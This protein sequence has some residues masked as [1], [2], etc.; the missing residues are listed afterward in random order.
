MDRLKFTTRHHFAF[1][2]SVPRKLLGFL[3]C[4]WASLGV[5][6]ISYAAIKQPNGEYRE[7]MDDLTVKVLGGYVTI[8]R[9]WQ[10]D[11]QNKG[12]FRW[13]FNPAWAD[14]TFTY[15][16]I[17]GSVK[18]ITRADSSFTKTGTGV[19]VFDQVFFIRQTPTGW[20]WYNPIGNWITYDPDGKITAYGDRNNVSVTF[21]RNADGTINQLLDNNSQAVLTY[22]YTNGQ[23]TKIAD[24]S[25]RS[26]SYQYTEGQLT[27]VTD[28]LTYNWIYGYTG[29]LLTSKMD[30]NNHQ[31][32]I[33]YSGNRVVKIKDPMQYETNYSYAY[34][35][36]KRVYTV[37]ETSPAGVRT[38][39]HYDT[40]GKVI[41]RQIGSRVV[42]QMIKDGTNVEIHIDERGL[43]TRVV[44]DTLRNPIEV[45]NPDGTKTTTT[46]G[47]Q[48]NNVS[49]YT[50]EAGIQ[51][52]YQYDANGNLTQTTE[53]VGLP[54][55]RITTFTYDGYGQP[56]TRTIKGMPVPIG[57]TPG[58]DDTQYQD[59]TT[60]LTYD[61]YGNVTTIADPMQHTATLTEDVMGNVLTWKDARTFTTKYG[62][63]ARGWPI[64]Q[65]DP[66]G[67]VVGADYDKV[68]N[69]TTI[70][71][72]LQNTT[73]FAYNPND[74]LTSV[75]D[76]PDALG[77]PSGV[78][79]LDY[80]H[81][82]RLTSSCDQSNVCTGYGYDGDGR[83][84]STTDG[85]GNVTTLQYGNSSNG[86][87]GLVAVT[88]YPT[89]VEQYKYDS[90]NRRTQLIQILP[91][92]AGQPDQQ[93]AS[94]SGY[95][96]RGNLISV[97]DPRG[98]SALTAFD[99]L[100]RPIQVTDALAGVTKQ[101]YNNRDSV[102]TVTDAN[103]NTHTFSYDLADRTIAESRPLGG[104]IRYAYDET[105]DLTSRINPKGERIVYTYD[106]AGRQTQEDQ[107]PAGSS[108]ASQTVVYNYDPRDLLSGYTQTGDTLSSASYG[109]DAKG[110]KKNETVTY[111]AG[112]SAFSKTIK[113][114]YY[115]N[116]LKQFFT[117]PDGTVVSYSY[118]SN[119]ELA[120][121]T[122]PNGQTIQFTNFVWN[123]PTQ[124][125]KPG[126]VRNI[127]LD[128]L[129]RPVEIKA[130]A[131][132]SG[133]ANAP[134][135]AIVMNY[136]YTYDPAGNITKRITEDGEYDYTYDGLYRLTSATPPLSVQRS[137]ANP[138]GLPVEQYTYDA[139]DNRT[140]SAHQPGPWTYNA[141]NQLL[142]Y[143]SGSQ[144]QTYRYDA[145]GNTVQQTTGDPGVS[146]VIRVFKY[147]TAE[148][149]MEVEDNDVSIGTYLYDPMGRR[150]WKQAGGQA[151]WFQYADEGTVAEYT[152]NGT[153]E[154][155]YGLQPDGDWETDPLW[156]A[157]LQQTAWTTSF[158]DNDHLG[159][160]Q[161]ATSN[162]GSVVWSGLAEAFGRTD[163]TITIVLNPMRFPGQTLDRETGLHYN[164]FREYEPRIGRYS[165]QDPAGLL[166]GLNGYIYVNGNPISAFDPYGLFY[167]PDIQGLANGV[168]GFG[169]GVFRVI[170]FGFG[171]LNR[172]RGI[173]GID[174]G[175]DR[176]SK[177]YRYAFEAG[178]IE[179][180]FALGGA[181]GLLGKGV[182]GFEF[183]H[184]VPARY[185]KW[186]N[187]PRAVVNSRL[188]GAY[189][190]WY[191]HAM[192][193]VYRWRFVPKRLKPFIPSLP[194]GAAQLL[195]LPP[196]LIGTAAG[197]TV[198]DDCG[199]QQ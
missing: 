89:F 146:N 58:P 150:I 151:T 113:Y 176:C 22:T 16:S 14:L 26:V 127:A 115:P 139:V 129:Q 87:S 156:L 53:A 124:I 133:T 98:N 191:F 39:T 76:A 125:Q 6:S 97:T 92:S 12:K 47:T 187:L 41:Y 182:R 40:R 148:R 81:D 155:G 198:S 181:L 165:R 153:M 11:D 51:T 161:R 179:G 19:F 131:I 120:S 168:T 193:D 86:L 143:G 159:A 74:W 20:R 30:P 184:T 188:N 45:D 116:G 69:R 128:P 7:T 174:G 9:T 189:V 197:S 10:A 190:P 21:T 145:N 169:D 138:S 85:A 180:G 90:R 72:P 5:T 32:V 80:D 107:Y 8:S 38:E 68:G 194:N 137:A 61:S 67:H 77:S 42:S 178:G 117:Y 71:D 100:N 195:R 94:T 79:A 59:A 173:A 160:S 99:A 141:D 167:L 177:V 83:L 109:Y 36:F 75:T 186:Y 28:P 121:A 111:G 149:P 15:D 144:Q 27:Q 2:A 114:D 196:W 56:L 185:I 54:E 31:T 164:Y 102:L 103:G 96:S 63:N 37:V 78:S 4:L 147:N 123:K 175:I 93:L 62:Y 166:T 152:Q 84:T 140:S 91:G 171:D 130:Q 65:T 50:D 136:Q 18:Q 118:T 23:V 88:I 57:V 163:E 29:G 122:T 126:V 64:S 106:S 52:Q 101:T 192:T 66:L 170:T 25:G 55:Q 104:T 82:G 43:Q 135:G 142:G 132:G 17:D 105:G 108:T 49:N 158:F 157:D 3:L 183:S 44:Y 60:T 34:D 46:F 1:R 70:T 33:T 112:P 172:I 48:Y 119:N 199:C 154:R 24:Y 35:H 73:T 13:Y 110:Q 162:D 95:D 134:N